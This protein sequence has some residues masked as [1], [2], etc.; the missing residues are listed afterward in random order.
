MFGWAHVDDNLSIPGAT[1]EMLASIISMNAALGILFG[2]YF[3]KFGLEC[4]MLTHFLVDAVF[5]ALVVPAYLSMNYLI[6][7][8]LGSASLITALMSLRVLTRHR[9]R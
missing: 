3:W 7:F 2:W 4:A 6:W 1:V 9:S 8:G 5:S